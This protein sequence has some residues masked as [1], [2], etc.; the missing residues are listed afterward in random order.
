VDSEEAR[1]ELL[2]VRLDKATTLG[3]ERAWSVTVGVVK[4]IAID[5]ILGKL[6]VGV[7]LGFKIVPQLRGGL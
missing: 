3:L 4:R 1:V 6:A 5:S 7:P 2:D